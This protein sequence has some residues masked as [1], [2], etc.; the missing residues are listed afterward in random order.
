MVQGGDFLN[1]DGTG[2]LSIYGKH[3]EDENFSVKVKL[4]TFL[5]PIR[6]VLQKKFPIMLPFHI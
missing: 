1:N 3:F 4:F 5:F 2:S 6:S